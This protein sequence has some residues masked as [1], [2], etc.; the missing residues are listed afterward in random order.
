M[1]TK[2]KTI[3]DGDKHQTEDSKKVV[4]MLLG[5]FSPMFLNPFSCE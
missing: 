4:A 5:A 2:Y 1:L 3:N